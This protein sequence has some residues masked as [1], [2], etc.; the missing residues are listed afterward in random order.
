MTQTPKQ[1]VDTFNQE[2]APFQKAII[3][4]NLKYKEAL[5]TFLPKHLEM[6]QEAWQS[7]VDDYMEDLVAQDYVREA[8]GDALEDIA[9]HYLAHEYAF[10]HAIQDMDMESDAWESLN[11][12]A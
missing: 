4:A 9:N 6:T 3:E 2:M 5:A 11:I 8:H 10:R 7:V 12:T 1:L